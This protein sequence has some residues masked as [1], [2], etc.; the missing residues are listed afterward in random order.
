MDQSTWNP[1]DYTVCSELMFYA[2]MSVV[3]GFHWFKWWTKQFVFILICICLLWCL[4]IH[5]HLSSE[6]HFETVMNSSNERASEIMIYGQRCAH[7]CE[8]SFVNRK[9]GQIKFELVIERTEVSM[10]WTNLCWKY[11]AIDSIFFLL[12]FGIIKCDCVYMIQRNGYG[13]ANARFI[14]LL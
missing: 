2:V 13:T 14:Y 8:R 10:R 12:F 4:S 11:S 1:S 6:K 9:A 3:F 7:C 5:S